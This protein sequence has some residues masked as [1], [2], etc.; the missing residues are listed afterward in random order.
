MFFSSI[1]FNVKNKSLMIFIKHST[2]KT[3]YYNSGNLDTG[4]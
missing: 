1:A 3:E 2:D 4:R